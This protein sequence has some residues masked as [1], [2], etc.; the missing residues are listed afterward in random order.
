ME[1]KVKRLKLILSFFLKK[2][3]KAVIWFY[4]VPKASWACGVQAKGSDF[5][6]TYSTCFGGWCS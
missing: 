6:G 1:V 3:L 4:H 2:I 5:K